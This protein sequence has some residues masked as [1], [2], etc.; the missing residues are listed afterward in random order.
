MRLRVIDGSY[1]GRVFDVPD[2]CFRSGVYE[3]CADLQPMVLSDKDAPLHLGTIE[4][5]RFCLV[6]SSK[7]TYVLTENRNVEG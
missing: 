1:K 3:R 6:L 5:K 7:H 2:Q 4:I